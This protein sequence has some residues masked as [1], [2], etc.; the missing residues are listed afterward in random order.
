MITND[1]LFVKV[2][3]RLCNSLAGAY[4]H[5]LD[6]C[7]Y[8]LKEG[9]HDLYA[10]ERDALLRSWRKFAETLTKERHDY[11]FPYLMTEEDAKTEGNQ[12]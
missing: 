10:R 11:K 5:T 6:L 7:G 3:K 12:E 1:D 8:T 9:R 2:Q 4:A